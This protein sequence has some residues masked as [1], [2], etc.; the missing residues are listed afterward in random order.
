VTYLLTFRTYGTWLHGDQRG[1]VDRDNNQVGMP[2][3]GP[4]VALQ[5]FRRNAMNAP[6]VG[7]D[8]ECCDCVRVT[9]KEVARY[10]GWRLRAINVLPNHVHIV[11]ETNEA[12]TLANPDKL[13][14][15]FKAWGTRR[16]REAQH[17]AQE[18]PIWAEKGSTRYLKTLESIERAIDYVLNQQEF[19]GDPCDDSNDLDDCEPRA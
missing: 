2:L 5:R 8:E 10:R 16:L 11:V 1:S 17:F 7:F 18:Q 14:A 12:V 6:P 19:P 13:A 15:D 4:N 3:I 9:L